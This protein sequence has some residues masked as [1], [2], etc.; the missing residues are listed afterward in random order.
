MLEKTHNLDTDDGAECG[1]PQAENVDETGGNVAMR[2][3]VQDVD[4]ELYVK[5]P[6]LSK[7][8]YYDA[9]VSSTDIYVALTM[10]GA[11][12]RSRYLSTYYW[13]RYN[14]LNDEFEARRRGII[15]AV[16][17]MNQLWQNVIH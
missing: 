3:F 2:H 11:S 13:R 10:P 6:E 7:C 14:E 15:S 1:C 16:N 8:N 12:N 5:D 9:Y 17:Q 4:G